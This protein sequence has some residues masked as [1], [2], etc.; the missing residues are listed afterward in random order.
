MIG[1]VP[2]ASTTILSSW[3][4]TTVFSHPPGL[5]RLREGDRTVQPEPGLGAGRRPAPT[6]EVEWDNLLHLPSRCRVD[7][8]LPHDPVGWLS[9]GPVP[10]VL[11]RAALL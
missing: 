9:G 11:G 1:V 4:I 7:P 10:W 8:P 3:T 5:L 2:P 6:E